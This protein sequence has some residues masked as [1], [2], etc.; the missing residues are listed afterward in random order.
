MGAAKAKAKSETARKATADEAKAGIKAAQTIKVSGKDYLQVQGRI[1]MF[2]QDHPTGQIHTEYIT[3]GTEP[4]N[5]RYLARAIVLVNDKPVSVG[6]KMVKLDATRGPGK[7]WPFEMA[8][9]G[10]IG[11]ALGALGYGTLSGDFDEVAADQ[12]AD[13]PVDPKRKW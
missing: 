12:I 8:E 9:T 1:L 3:Q 13:A 7:D 4:D 2:R 11:R 5:P 6:H 10:A